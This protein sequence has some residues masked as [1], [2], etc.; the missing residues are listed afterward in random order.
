MK[1]NDGVISITVP[2]WVW[3]L[4]IAALMLVVAVMMI[5]KIGFHDIIFHEEWT[6]ETFCRALFFTWMVGGAG[7]CIAATVVHLYL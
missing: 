5:K 3:L 6:T 4:I 1:M 7:V 2:G